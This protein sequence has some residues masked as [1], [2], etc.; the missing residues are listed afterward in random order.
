MGKSCGLAPAASRVV[1]Q[2]RCRLL[3]PGTPY[4]ALAYKE[5]EAAAHVAKVVLRAFE[6]HSPEEIAPQ[7]E[8]S[9]AAGAGGL[10]CLS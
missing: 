10:N 3:N 7:L 6:V 5:L 8:A 4:A 1:H 2:L 9:K